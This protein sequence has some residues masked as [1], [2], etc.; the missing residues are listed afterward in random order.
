MPSCFGQQR[1]VITVP[2]VLVAAAQVD[3]LHAL[4]RFALAGLF[5]VFLG[6]DDVFAGEVGGPIFLALDNNH[7]LTGT[8]KRCGKITVGSYCRRDGLLGYFTPMT[9]Y[10]RHNI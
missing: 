9:V 2:Q 10:R 5:E 3:D 6:R 7:D 4:A 1:A 8:F